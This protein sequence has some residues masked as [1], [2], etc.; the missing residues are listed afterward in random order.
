MSPA[1]AEPAEAAVVATP[2][3]G[4]ALVPGA[5]V[6]AGSVPAGS[7][8]A[9]SVPAGTVLA[10]SELGG[11]VAEADEPAAAAMSATPASAIVVLRQW[12]LM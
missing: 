8:P 7:V 9:G 4:A 2:A 10:G 3:S 11:V 12:R 5:A 6:P 1:G